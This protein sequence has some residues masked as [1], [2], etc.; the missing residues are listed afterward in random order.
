MERNKTISLEKINHTQMK[1]FIFVITNVFLIVQGTQAQNKELINITKNYMA[2][3]VKVTNAKAE[4]SNEKSIL[5]K[6]DKQ[7][8]LVELYAPNKVW[9]LHDN[10][11]VAFNVSNLGDTDV[12]LSCH[13]DENLWSQGLF[14]LKPGENGVMRVLIKGY[15]LP[16]SH[17]LS[18][19]YKDM[20]GLPG[21][22]LQHWVKLD[23]AHIKKIKLSLVNPKEGATISICNIMA[24]GNLNEKSFVQLKDS[25]FPFVDKYGQYMHKEWEGKISSDKDFSG[26]SEME[27]M[28]LNASPSPA[29]RNQYGGWTKG[30]KRKATGHFRTEKIDGKWWLIDPEGCLFWSHGITGVGKGAATTKVA[31]REHYFANLPAKDSPRFQ[32][33]GKTKKGKI[34]TFNFTASNL[35]IK[36]GKDWKK[37]HQEM[38]HKRLKNW[39]MNTCGNWSDTE[40]YMLRKTPYTVSVNFAWKKVGGNLKF[41][42]V[43]D[44]DYKQNLKNTFIKHSDTWNDAYCIGYFV[45]NELHGWGSIGRNVLTSSASDN[46]KKELLIF[47]KKRYSNIEH[48]DAVW[49]SSYK[50]WDAL[51][52]SIQNVGGKAASSDLLDFEKKMVDLYYKSCREVIK[53]KAPN[54]LYLGSRLHNHYYPKD[55]KHQKWIVPIAAKYCDVISFNRYRFAPNDLIPHN[56]NIDKPIIIGEFHFGALD[57]GMLH[58]GLRSVQN[59]DQR[60]KAYFEY[61][62]AALENPYL[63]GAH[64]FQYGEQAVTGR[65]DGENYQIG[66]LD[67]CDSPYQETIIGCRKIGYQMYKVRMKS[68]VRIH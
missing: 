18:L 62:K 13:L 25:A 21:G 5:I 32:F 52:N 29:N 12:A 3:F 1:I 28:E 37:Q 41:P 30:E 4:L 38:A 33:A 14:L 64:W 26:I 35:Y 6:M 45:D 47:L 11:S 20:N 66:F 23:A 44:P 51:L 61:I 60:K 31:D 65:G 7:N 19:L 34:N 50:S 46:A 57:R 56:K 9:D 53:E 42:N 54:K 15:K 16:D 22:Y 39:G 43:F 63:V 55:A 36:Y 49:E 27:N 48:L 67:V 24:E 10:T 17:P 40:T 8:P 68:Q 59:Q 58:T 2:S